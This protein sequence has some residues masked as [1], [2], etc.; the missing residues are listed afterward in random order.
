MSR[1]RDDR[2]GP[3]RRC[4]GG[5]TKPPTPRLAAVEAAELARELRVG[6][7]WV[8]GLGVGAHRRLR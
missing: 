4:H 1:R 5:A 8:L 2:E 6:G 7:V 3:S